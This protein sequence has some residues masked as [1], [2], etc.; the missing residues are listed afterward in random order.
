M[1]LLRLGYRKTVASILGTLSP[2]LAYSLKKASCHV[3]AILLR[4]VNGKKLMSLT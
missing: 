1:S 4:S 3:I 2:S